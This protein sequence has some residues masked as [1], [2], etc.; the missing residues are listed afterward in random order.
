MG[1]MGIGS[2]GSMNACF[3]RKFRWMI[4]IQNIAG[5]SSAAILPPSKAARPNISFREIE[6][7]HLTE[8]VY[9]PGKPEW[10]PLNVTLYG[11]NIGKNPVYTWMT[12]LY[13]PIKESAYTYPAEKEFILSQITLRMLSAC[14][15]TIEE[16]TY[17]DCWLQNADFE[18]LDMSDSGVV[19]VNLTIRYARAYIVNP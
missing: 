12:K 7:Q 16:W 9:F 5:N 6:I 13:N 2:L 8:T 15:D 17:Q 4:E 14:G 18:E 10:K 19:N 11:L 3:L 1:E